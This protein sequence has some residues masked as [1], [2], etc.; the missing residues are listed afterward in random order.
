MQ[1]GYAKHKMIDVVCKCWTTWCFKQQTANAVESYYY[2]AVD[3]LFSYSM[4]MCGENL[5]FL[6][7]PDLF[8]L[9]LKNEGPIPCNAMILILSNRK[10]N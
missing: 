2:M 1:N 4:L 3:F 8:V 5:Q 7:F 6:E 9:L 10:M